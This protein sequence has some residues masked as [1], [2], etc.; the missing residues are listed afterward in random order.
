MF[1]TRPT[2]AWNPGQALILVRLDATYYA[3]NKF[4]MCTVSERSGF[5]PR[6]PLL[7]PWSEQV[8]PPALE[9]FVGQGSLLIS[10]YWRKTRPLVCVALET[11]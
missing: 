3:S 8:P 4:M 1:V 9:P 5:A 10:S 7:F 11:Q 6:G 2:L